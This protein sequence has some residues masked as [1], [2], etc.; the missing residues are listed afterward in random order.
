[1][2]LTSIMFY[3]YEA[4][5]RTFLNMSLPTRETKMVTCFSILERRLSS[6]SCLPPRLAE[7]ASNS[8]VNSDFLMHFFARYL[9]FI[10]VNLLGI[11][12]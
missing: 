3:R 6:G 2:L 10:R 11:I 4:T 5:Q 7:F 8:D 1:L 9:R 12:T